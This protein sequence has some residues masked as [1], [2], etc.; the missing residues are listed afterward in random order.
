MDDRKTQK[1]LKPLVFWYTIGKTAV[2]FT[3]SSRGGRQKYIPKTGM[4]RKIML[5]SSPLLWRGVG[6][7]QLPKNGD[8]TQKYTICHWKRA[9]ILPKNGDDTQKYSIILKER[10]RSAPKNGDDTQKYAS[11]KP[12]TQTRV[13]YTNLLVGGIFF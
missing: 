6:A 10:A 8:D 13:N 2:P 11:G 12:Y 9:N 5:L 4:I 3:P 7:N 1:L